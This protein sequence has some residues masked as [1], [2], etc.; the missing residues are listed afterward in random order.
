[1]TFR[2]E[3]DDIYYNKYQVVK[4]IGEGTFGKVYK[5]KE[6]KLDR[7]EALKI[8]DTKKI[9][10]Q[11]FLNEINGIKNV[12][13]PNIVKLYDFEYSEDD[14]PFMSTEYVKGKE[15]ERI[16]HEEGKFTLKRTLN[17]IIQILDAL[18]ETHTRG[19]I[20]CDLK[21]E[22]IILTK[23]GAKT[24]FVKLLDFGIATILSKQTEQPQNT[25]LMGTPQYMA[26]EQIK[27]EQLGPWTDIYAVGLI[28]L[29]LLTGI[30]QVTGNNPRE[31]LLKQLQKNIILPAELASF[32]IGPILAKTIAKD[33]GQRYRDA[34]HLH[35]DLMELLQNISLQ[36]LNSADNPHF[37]V[38]PNTGVP[39]IEIE[40]DEP[41]PEP[42]IKNEPLEN[43]FNFDDIKIK[44]TTNETDPNLH[45]YIDEFLNI[46]TT[47][48]INHHHH[49]YY[50]TTKD[51]QYPRAVPNTSR[52][53]IRIPLIL[54]LIITICTAAYLYVYKPG[55]NDN[56]NFD[57]VLCT[58]TKKQTKQNNIPEI[59]KKITYAATNSTLTGTTINTTNHITIKIIAS[60]ANT[61][62]RNNNQILCT[63]SPC[64]VTLIG[65]SK[66]IKLHAVHGDTIKHLN[67]NT[68]KN[69]ETLLVDLKK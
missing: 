3:K 62:I 16:L 36:K 44:N 2:L 54:M 67:T 13:H 50:K 45:K 34:L 53:H 41:A 29:E 28:T 5:V 1:M 33:T 38:E 69:R 15:L 27:K 7:C 51:T 25:P 64:I 24:D 18:V 58:D 32:F 68:L 20:H 17:I 43:T 56:N 61:E 52:T 31:I 10:R 42:E 47:E 8:F 48:P 37:T 21:P 9:P 65:N 6:L 35:N 60:P 11:L 23:V 57:T 55:I 4:L 39:L 59:I 40:P 26:P 19:I 22:N 12:E 66:K 30:T 63:K 46:K 49:Q 14:Y